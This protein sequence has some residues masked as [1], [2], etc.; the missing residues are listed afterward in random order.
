MTAQT[1]GRAAT[2]I[3]DELLSLSS[4]L[5]FFTVTA[6]LFRSIEFALVVTA[7]LGAHELGHAAMLA[8]F[9]LE[10]RIGFGLVGAWT[11]SL[12]RERARLSE[13]SNAAIH[14]AGPLFSLLLAMLALGLNHIWQ[15]D[16]HH[17][18]VLANFSAQIG[19]LN[20]L[21][22][23]SLTDGGKTVRRMI[24]SLPVET[25]RR[26]VFLPFY[27]TALMLLLYALV[28]L[29]GGE[30]GLT[31]RIILGL[32]L[33]GTWLSASI[34]YEARRAGNELSSPARAM[35]APQVFVLTLFIWNLLLLFLIVMSASLFWLAPEYV[36]GAL[37]NITALAEWVAGLI[38][39]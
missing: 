33:V 2:L 26:A 27:L 39:S 19:F 13:F 25:R 6:L 4:L 18:L 24:R 30:Q 37:Q 12:S 11:W 21:P 22:L 20:L 16:S 5:L 35:N 10:Y 38:G 31:S 17:L 34:F 7:S 29:S 15:P 36:L 3:R 14:L 9:K 8:R 23:G 28:E 1:S 32:L